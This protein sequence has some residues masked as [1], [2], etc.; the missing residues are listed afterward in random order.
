MDNK[1][2]CTFYSIA[3]CLGQKW[4]KFL[5]TT[6]A[7]SP[8]AATQ[9]V[10]QRSCVMNE[11]LQVQALIQYCCGC[12]FNT[13]MILLWN[14]TAASRARRNDRHSKR[15][16][17]LTS[18]CRHFHTLRDGIPALTSSAKSTNPTTTEC[19]QPGSVWGEGAR[20]WRREWEREGVRMGVTECSVVLE[21]VMSRYWE[22]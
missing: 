5:Q 6:C 17:A 21:R 8:Q 19:E 2:C 10:Q 18:S 14:Q 1:L 11:P 3:L 16:A 22:S 4:G 12:L 9:S 13:V 20:E 15:R 7:E